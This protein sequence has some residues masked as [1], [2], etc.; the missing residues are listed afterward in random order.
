MHQPGLAHEAQAGLRDPAYGEGCRAERTV[1]E[2]GACEVLLDVSSESAAG[3]RGKQRHLVR[4]IFSPALTGTRRPASGDSLTQ[5]LDEPL[6]TQASVSAPSGSTESSDPG[7][8]SASPGS[9]IETSS[10]RK[11]R[12]TASAILRRLGEIRSRRH[13]GSRRLP[14]RRCAPSSTQQPAFDRVHRRR[15]DKSGDEQI[16]RSVVEHLRRVVLFDRA[17][18]Q[19]RDARRHRHRFDLVVRDV[20]HGGP[21]FGVQ[22]LD[23]DAHL[24]PQLG[25]E[26]GQRLVEQ[27]DRRPC[28]R[29][30]ARSRRAGAAR[31]KAGWA[32]GPGDRRSA[33]GAP[34]P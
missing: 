32:C 30:R 10:G 17:R 3:C 8:T 29:W 1:R 14:P 7:S 28:A 19:H 13:R 27:E 18:V 11:P 22:A 9:A 15:A 6:S 21:E 23:L 2:A 33:A 25:V 34:P 24:G 26:I 12:T 4:A 16:R 20:D 31:R 5:S